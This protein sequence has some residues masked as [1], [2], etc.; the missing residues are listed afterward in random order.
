MNQLTRLPPAA[1]EYVAQY[2]RT[3]SEPTRLHILSVLTENELSVGE[4]ADAVGSSTANVSRHLAQMAQRGLVTRSQSGSTVHYRVADPAVHEL[5]DLVC[6][7]IAQRFVET[8]GLRAA[9]KTAPPGAKPVEP[10]RK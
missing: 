1:L 10:G 5:C 2:F 9:F 8:A 7:S 4:I 6:N 3:L